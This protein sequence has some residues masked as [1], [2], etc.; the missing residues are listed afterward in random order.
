MYSNVPPENFLPLIV[1]VPKSHTYVE[2]KREDINRTFAVLQC[3]SSRILP[4]FK[5]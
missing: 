5:S 3:S 4:G 1:V 2:L